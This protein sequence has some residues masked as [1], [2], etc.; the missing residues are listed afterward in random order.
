MTGW[1]AVLLA[2][3]RPNGDPLAKAMN[4]SHKA[5]IPV[6]GE[7][8]LLRPLRA[9]LGIA[10]IREIIVLT[11]EPSAIRSTLPKDDRVSVRPSRGTIAETVE[12]LILDKA[13]AFPILVTTADHALLS[14]A[15]IGEFLDEA[16]GADLALGLVERKRLLKRFPDAKRTWVHLRGG[17]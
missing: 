11:Q 6:A 17:S 2:G 4:A 1:T 14:G 13:V 10:D 9:L 8:M 7:P 5:L 15:M 16:E 12:E 3:S